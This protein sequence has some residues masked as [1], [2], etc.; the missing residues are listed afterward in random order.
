MEDDMKDAPQ[1]LEEMRQKLLK[2]LHEKRKHI[3]EQIAK[4]EKN[5]PD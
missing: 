2:E 4:L 3:D 1:A 5:K